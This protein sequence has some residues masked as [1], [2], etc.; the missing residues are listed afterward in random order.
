MKGHFEAIISDHAL[1]EAKKGTASV[2]FRLTANKNILTGEDIQ[3]EAVFFDAWLTDT[4]FDGTMKTLSDS[5]GWTGNDFNDFN[6][7][8]KFVGM[9]VCIVCE[10]E[11]YEN[12][13]RTKV[14]FMNNINRVPRINPMD[15]GKVRNLAESLKG[16]AMAYRQKSPAI[17]SN[18]G[19]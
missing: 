11:T 16:K 15:S 1:A 4:A 10:E 19:F 14:K 13:I 5:L 9:K 2:K 7:T 3:P 17:P 12:K 18:G 8:G 6:G